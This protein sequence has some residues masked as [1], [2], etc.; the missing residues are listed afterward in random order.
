MKRLTTTQKLWG[1]LGIIWIAMLLLVGWLAWENRQT[2]EN[3]RRASIEH[4]VKSVHGQLE[5]LQK[6]AELGELTEAEAQ[7]RA[8]D[9]IAS[10]RFGDGEYVFA[11]DNNLDIVSH[12]NRPRAVM[13]TTSHAVLPVTAK[14]RRL[15]MSRIYRNGDGRWRREFTWMTSTLPLSPG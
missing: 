6:R 15:A 12:P 2:L 10:V 1:T 5:A 13:W 11:F 7:Q 14:C 3:E 9:N 4:I 8:I